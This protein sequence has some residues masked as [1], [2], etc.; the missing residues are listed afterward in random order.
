MTLGSE[1]KEGYAG[2]SLNVVFSAAKR[3]GLFETHFSPDLIR[4]LISSADEGSKIAAR[5]LLF[6]LPR[7]ADNQT[8]AHECLRVILGAIEIGNYVKNEV[9]PEEFVSATRA[10][11][12]LE[13]GD[14]QDLLNECLALGFEALG[15]VRATSSASPFGTKR[16]VQLITS[17]LERC[18][19]GM[20]NAE[21]NQCSF[22]K[23][24]F[25]SEHRS[26][27]YN[28]ALLGSIAAFRA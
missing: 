27:Q 3:L 15:L 25:S 10:L 4:E 1:E 22:E 14:G 28:R 23:S 6:L 24:L 9:N 20:R 8:L 13:N 11:S 5:T 21:E 17:F 18:V 7:A 19:K 26:N 16:T 12:E 2:L